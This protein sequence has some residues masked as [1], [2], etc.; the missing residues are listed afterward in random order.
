M[1][2]VIAESVAQGI[3]AP[4]ST[5]Q[6]HQCMDYLITLS[7]CENDISYANFMRDIMVQW[8]FLHAFYDDGGDHECPCG[9]A[10]IKNISV[11]QNVR[12]LEEVVIGSDCIRNF[13]P[14]HSV[15]LD[16]SLTLRKG[17][18]VTLTGQCYRHYQFRVNDQK[19]PI[20]LRNDEMLEKVEHTP[21]TLED[22]GHYY[23]KVIKSTDKEVSRSLKL[24]RRYNIVVHARSD[25][26]RLRYVFFSTL[27]D[28]QRVRDESAFRLV[29]EDEDEEDEY[30][31]GEPEES[32]HKD[33]EEPE[34]SQE[35]K[36]ESEDSDEDEESDE[37][38]EEEE[39]DEEEEVLPVSRKRGR[40]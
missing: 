19:S 23:I 20:I 30:N 12:T 24:N 2:G 31:E 18:D 40:R 11:I 39:S 22:D 15:F 8:R 28:A 3:D 21:L 32:S 10:H 33:V 36:E 16:I 27:K 6:F 4:S 9:Q 1:Q 14:G 17:L 26:T 7:D 37:E 29:E 13:Y 38:E 25:G 5:R 35:G 34:N